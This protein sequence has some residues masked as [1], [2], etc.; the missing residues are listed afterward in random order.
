MGFFDHRHHWRPKTG[1][2]KV[3]SREN[4]AFAVSI[5]IVEDCYCGAVRTIEVEPGKAPE[6]RIS[7]TPISGP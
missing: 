5:L 7:L 1:N 4:P 6:V 2:N 3:M